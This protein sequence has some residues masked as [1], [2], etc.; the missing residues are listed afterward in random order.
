MIALLAEELGIIARIIAS[1]DKKDKFDW[2]NEEDDKQIEAVFQET[3]KKFGT[4]KFH[5]SSWEKQQETESFKKAR[6]GMPLIPIDQLI[7]HEFYI[8]GL[9]CHQAS[10]KDDALNFYTKALNQV[11]NFSRNSLRLS[12]LENIE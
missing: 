6:K 8:K 7:Q 9:H 5:F 12:T 4:L 1:Y 10:Q 2:L 11:G 3:L